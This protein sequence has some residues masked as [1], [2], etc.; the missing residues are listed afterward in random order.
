MY[1][2]F[3][4]KKIH[5]IDLYNQRHAVA[6]ETM[7]VVPPPIGSYWESSKNQIANVTKVNRY[8]VHYDI[9]DLHTLKVRDNWSWNIRQPLYLFIQ[10]K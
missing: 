6:M 5:T 4:E 2:I 9:I 10:R 8:F 7:T 1:A 3:Y